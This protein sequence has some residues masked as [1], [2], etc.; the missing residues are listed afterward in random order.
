MSDSPKTLTHSL[1]DPSVDRTTEG[2]LENVTQRRTYKRGHDA[3]NDLR[4]EEYTNRISKMLND[5]KIEFGR[6][7]AEINNT[8]KNLNQSTQ[9][10][11]S[12]IA[13]IREEYTKMK[14][15]VGGL[16]SRQNKMAEELA[17]LHKSMKFHSDEYEDIKKKLDVHTKELKK[18]NSLEAELS[19]IK[20]QNRKLRS[21]INAYDQRERQLNVEI[22]G[23]PEHKDEN[24]NEII[25]KIGKHTEIEITKDD[26]LQVNRVTAKSKIQGRPR[27]IVA[28]LR[29]RQLKDNIIS[30]ARKRR[31]STMDLAIPGKGVPVYVNEHLTVFNKN[32][33]KK[34][35]EMAKIK[36]Y[37]FM[38]TK[39]CKIYVRKAATI[40]LIIITEEEDLK[41]IV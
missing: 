2:S 32:L 22:V 16:G 40:P 6:D 36:E 26:I 11:K 34:A 23:I 12:E 17:S 24:L 27:N 1:P 4:F 30:Q 9:E 19:E 37:Q 21:D 33:L 15:T 13:C 8:M 39:N 20:D 18:L 10:L 29:N 38:W 41:K 31:L 5:W 25:L 7:I 3:E 14:N 28:K 35:K